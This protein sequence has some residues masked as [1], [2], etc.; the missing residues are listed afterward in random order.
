MSE[1]VTPPVSSGAVLAAVLL[2]VIALGLQLFAGEGTP[3]IAAR[4]LTALSGGVLL[5]HWWSIRRRD[6]GGDVVAEPIGGQRIDLAQPWTSAR[7]VAL[8]DA[9]RG[10]A[11]ELTGDL[12][13]VGNSAAL[14]SARLARAVHQTA[15]ARKR[16]SRGRS[17]ILPCWTYQAVWPTPYSPTAT[18]AAYQ[19]ENWEAVCSRRRID[20]W[21]SSH[22]P[23]RATAAHRAKSHS[24]PYLFK[25]PARPV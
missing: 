22:S 2:L 12:R 24:T 18:P 11:R 25:N 23:A 10:Q 9:L 5:W 14:D 8:G 19:E 4:I 20:G 1:G 3:A 21:A 6:G 7:A 13:K 17:L 15:A 16:A